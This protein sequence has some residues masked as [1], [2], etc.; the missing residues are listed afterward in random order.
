[1]SDAG[2]TSSTGVNAG[3]TETVGTISPETLLDIYRKMVL[4]RTLDE[5][6]WQLNRQGR[7]ALVAS[8]QGHEGAQVGTV[9]ALRPGT[10]LFYTYYRDLGVMI[11]VGMTP[12]QIMLAYMARAGEPMSGARQFPSQGAMPEL[13][14]VNLSNVVATH[15]SQGVGA[16]LAMRMQGSDALAAVYFGDG[17]SSTGDCHEAMNF[18]AVHSV[19]VIFVCENN[20]WAISVPVSQQMAVDSVASRAAGYGMPG[21]T[22]DGTD[23]AAVYEVTEAAAARARAGE[24]PTLIEVMVERFRPHT[25]DDDHTRYRSAEDLEAALKRDPI[26]ALRSQLMKSGELDEAGDAEIAD[27]AMREIDEATDFAE[28][29]P[30]P[31]PATFYDHVYAD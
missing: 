19:P 21:V 17:A 26:K 8:S 2:N 6:V 31:D 22:V 30:L 15:L 12:A 1:M 18:A 28:A 29:A 13:G 14:L 16:A 3:A 25:G 11:S 5:R 4:T 20:G 7:A 27:A 23:V 10:D 9:A 24:G